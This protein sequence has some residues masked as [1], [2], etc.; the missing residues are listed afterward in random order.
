MAMKAMKAKVTLMIRLQ[1][2]CLHPVLK[3]LVKG[4]MLAKLM[5]R[6]PAA[7]MMMAKAAKDLKAYLAKFLM[8]F[9]WM[10]ASTS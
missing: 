10:P 3:I 8:R 6:V 7:A 9:L 4:M 5:K 1:S 2:L